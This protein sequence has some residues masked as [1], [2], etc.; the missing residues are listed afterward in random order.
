MAQLY[1][2]AIGVVAVW[3]AAGPSKVNAQKCGAVFSFV[4]EKGPFA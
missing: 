3:Q 1:L 2:E 4:F